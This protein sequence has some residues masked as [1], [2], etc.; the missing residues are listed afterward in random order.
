MRILNDHNGWINGKVMLDYQDCTQLV[1][2]LFY[3][4]HEEKRE[5]ELES[6]KIL[7]GQL[8]AILKSF[9]DDCWWRYG[10][11]QGNF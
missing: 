9:D 1:A 6:L 2:A 3:L 8:K 7:R 10:D 4:I 11:Y 5:E